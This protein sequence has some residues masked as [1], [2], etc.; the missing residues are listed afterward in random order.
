MRAGRTLRTWEPPAP[1]CVST[2]QPSAGL[3]HGGG[4]LQPA[5][6]RA[7]LPALP[8]QQGRARLQLVPPPCG[9]VPPAAPG[10][11]SSQPPDAFSPVTQPFPSRGWLT[12][13]LPTWQPL[14]ADPEIQSLPGRRANNPLVSSLVPDPIFTTTRSFC[15]LALRGSWDAK[16][17]PPADS[18]P[19]FC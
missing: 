4:P 1:A 11:Q 5:S 8:P 3:L 2:E 16:P 18:P 9:P 6:F 7:P 12:R 13:A 15:S 10:T 19:V 14:D 17:A